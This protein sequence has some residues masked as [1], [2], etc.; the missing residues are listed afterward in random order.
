MKVLMIGPARSV[1]GGVSAVVNNYYGA[2]LD[3]KISL[4]YIGTMVDGSKPRKLLQ[5]MS[6]WV[7]FLFFLPGCQLVHVNM[8]SDS[9][10][11]R[12]SVFIRTA[13]AFQKKIVLH[14]H[15]G[16]FETFYAGLSEGSKRRVRRVLGMAEVMLVLA[17]SWKR[18]FGTLVGEEKVIV[19]PDAI[20]IPP[21]VQKRYGQ[22]RILFL[23]RLCRE[24]GILELLDAVSILQ[25]E[26]PDLKLYL[27]G[28]WEDVAL[29]QK[30]A[31][32]GET[33]QWLGWVS[34]EEKRN[35]L[36]EC[37][38]FV[39]PSWF[40]GQSVALLEAM[41]SACAVVASDTGGI[42]LMVQDGQNGI[43][44][45]PR[46]R[47]SLIRGMRRVLADAPLAERLGRNARRTAAESYGLEENIKRLLSI[48]EEVLHGAGTV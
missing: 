22:R 29:Q 42:P 21:P 14:Q 1:H 13:H 48:Y 43:L 12:K 17:P 41:A 5:A 7:R 33:V 8:A 34:G 18:F 47:D 6:A 45:A 23:G 24:K 4:R 37:D 16:D 26:F 27:G 28:I 15:G 32:L 11:Y 38:L 44:V 40:E 31:A 19:L 9:S 3:Q 25:K 10:Y 46:D 20:P 2:G 36:A 39:M 35:Y 30:A